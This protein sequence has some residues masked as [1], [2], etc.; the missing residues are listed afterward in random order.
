MQTIA[1]E[2]L[3]Q[4]GLGKHEALVMGHGDRDHAHLHMMVNRVNPKTGV[5]WRVSHDYARFDRIMRDLA[6]HY[7]F[8]AVPADLFAPDV[9]DEMPKK[10]N[11]RATYAGKRGAQTT[12]LQW[13]RANA[14]ELGARISE[15]LVAASTWDDLSA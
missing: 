8:R 13:S 4:A 11:S 1:R 2:T 6:D 7:G 10:P 15:T 9:T 14:R 3:G 12:R 5:A